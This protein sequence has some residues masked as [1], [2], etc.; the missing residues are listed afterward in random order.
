MK[1]HHD[2]PKATLA[3]ENVRKMLIKVK[4]QH[5]QIASGLCTIWETP[6]IREASPSLTL[7]GEF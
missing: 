3:K 7:S 2:Q 5:D 4:V 6:F 1:G